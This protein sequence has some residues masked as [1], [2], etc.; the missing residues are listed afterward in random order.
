M[1]G[2]G[3]YPRRRPA[4]PGPGAGTVAGLIRLSHRAGHAGL[5]RPVLRY[6]FRPGPIRSLLSGY[7]SHGPAGRQRA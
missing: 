4:C 7:Y 5:A 6:V 1:I 3:P 2:P